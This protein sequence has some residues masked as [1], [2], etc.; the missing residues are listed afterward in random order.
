V[1]LFLDSVRKRKRDAPRIGRGLDEEP[2][3]LHDFS[4]ALD[5]VTVL[6]LAGCQ[7]FLQETLHEGCNIPL[8]A[9]RRDGQ[10]QKFIEG[11]GVRTIRCTA[12]TGTDTREVGTISFT[13]VYAAGPKGRLD[14][15]IEG[16][17]SLPLCHEDP[18]C[19]HHASQL[20]SVL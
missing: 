16:T 12:R 15:I 17:V 19:A 1:L 20:T 9:H 11:P 3:A 2:E 14:S 18:P 7:E 6:Q 13:D 4:L 10:R 5:V 8:N